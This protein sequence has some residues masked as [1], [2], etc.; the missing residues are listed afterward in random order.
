MVVAIEVVSNRA[1]EL[2][3]DIAAAKQC[4]HFL[5]R[6]GSIIIHTI[7]SFPKKEKDLYQ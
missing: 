5:D 2:R 6:A 7:P 3:R 4:S 1:I